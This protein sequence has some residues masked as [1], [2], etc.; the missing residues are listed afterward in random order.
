M[1]NTENVE[2]RWQDIYYSAIIISIINAVVIHEG[3]I[4]EKVSPFVKFEII[5]WNAVRDFITFFTKIQDFL[6]L[7]HN[8]FRIIL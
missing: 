7:Y 1:S 8:T 3:T 6:V 5:L 2:H 4:N